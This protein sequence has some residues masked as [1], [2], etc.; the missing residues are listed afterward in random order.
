M[1]LGGTKTEVR[2]SV[3]RIQPLRTLIMHNKI[4]EDKSSG[5]RNIFRL[6]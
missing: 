6:Y 3:I 5:C 2:D 1:A 4:E